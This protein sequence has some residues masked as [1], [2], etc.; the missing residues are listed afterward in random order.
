MQGG[1]VQVAAHT[2]PEPQICFALCWDKP[3]PELQGFSFA[4]VFSNRFP[5][6]GGMGQVGMP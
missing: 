6:A 4:F 1:A 2:Q 3:C 5:S